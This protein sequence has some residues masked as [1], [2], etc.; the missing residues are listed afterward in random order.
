MK[1]GLHPNDI[2]DV[3]VKNQ[4]AITSEKRSKDK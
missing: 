2:I 3:A 1:T 4:L